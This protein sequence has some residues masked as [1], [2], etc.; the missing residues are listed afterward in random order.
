MLYNSKEGKMKI[1]LNKFYASTSE[2][3][4]RENTVTVRLS[5][6]EIK[7]LESLSNGRPMS[8]FLRYLIFEIAL[9]DKK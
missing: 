3:G 6:S 8:T 5:D 4:K 1:D 9:K 2:D 7:K